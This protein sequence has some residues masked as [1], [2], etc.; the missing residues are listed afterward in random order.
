MNMARKARFSTCKK[1]AMVP[2]AEYCKSC[3]NPKLEGKYVRVLEAE[4]LESDDALSSPMKGRGGKRKHRESEK[5]TEKFLPQGSFKSLED[6]SMKYTI[7]LNQE[8]KSKL[9]HQ[10]QAS[11]YLA[12]VS[13]LV[14]DL[15]ADFYGG[16]GEKERGFQFLKMKT[17]IKIQ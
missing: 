6:F 12:V 9:F 11:L 13:F 8:H 3:A 7:E 10:V 1:S 14:Q 15:R 17:P 2:L 4:L 5:D 16:E